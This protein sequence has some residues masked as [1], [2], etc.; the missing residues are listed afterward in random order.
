[1]TMGN[2]N[3]NVRG[4]ASIAGALAAAVTGASLV[5]WWLS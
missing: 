4:L 1:M 2:G 5:Y 3:R